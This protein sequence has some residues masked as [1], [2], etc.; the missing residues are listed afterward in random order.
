MPR[1]AERHYGIIMFLT[2]G[3]RSLMPGHAHRQHF[4]GLQLAEQVRPAGELHSAT[5][6]GQAQPI[7]ELPF[8]YGRKNKLIQDTG[9][10]AH[11]NLFAERFPH[12]IANTR[13]VNRNLLHA[14]GFE[15]IGDAGHLF[16]PGQA[17]LGKVREHVGARDAQQGT[18]DVPRPRPHRPEARGPGPAQQAEEQGLRLVVPG[19]GQDDG[20]GAFRLLDRP[21]EGPP[22]VARRVFEPGLVRPGAAPD[23]GASG[24]D[25]D[26]EAPRELGAEGDVLLAL[27][28]E[29]VVEV[30]GHEAEAAASRQG[31]ESIGQSHGIGPSRERHHEGLPGATQPEAHE[32]LLDDDVEGTWPHD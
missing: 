10:A 1:Q 4:K 7:H 32:G 9:Q 13:S 3:A 5:T 21:Q 20:G 26:P 27:G 23:V 29:A 24:A 28:P 22:L 12:R 30:R 31:R 11:D 17:P 25:R 8:T 6:Q 2:G 18:H 19:V 16:P 14:P 15:D